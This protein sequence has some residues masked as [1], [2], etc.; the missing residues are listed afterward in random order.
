VAGT[1]PQGISNRGVIVGFY[2]DAS[3]NN[4]GFEYSPGR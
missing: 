1:A 2:T 3:G 4:H